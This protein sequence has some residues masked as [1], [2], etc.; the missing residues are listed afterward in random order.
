MSREIAKRLR[1]PQTREGF[2]AE[3]PAALVATQTAISA[4][5]TPLGG[6]PS[7]A[8]ALGDDSAPVAPLEA[9]RAGAGRGI[10]VLIGSTSEEYRL[11]FVPNGMVDRIR[12]GTVLLARLASGVPRRVVRAHRRRDPAASPGEVLGGIV[13]DMLLRA[14]I[15]RLAD[16][17]VDGPAGT[18]VYEFRWRSPVDGLGAAHAMELGFVFDALDTP[19]A[20]ALGGTEGPRALAEAMH[21]AWVSFVV[22]GDPG[23]EGWSARRPVQ[24]FDADGGHLDLDP[25]ADELDGLPQ[26]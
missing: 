16:S 20:V 9:L 15:T 3:K 6:G 17:R 24:A 18:W 2:A 23:W 14:P 8:L 21:A 19:D 1:V 4:Q 7:V 11:W 25:R 13:G 12:W 5:G 26:G 22:S 10:P